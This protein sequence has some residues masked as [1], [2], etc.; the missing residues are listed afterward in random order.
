MESKLKIIKWKSDYY[1][2]VIHPRYVF[3]KTCT[4]TLIE[5][6]EIGRDLFYDIISKHNC[7]IEF[8]HELNNE[9]KVVT[10]ERIY[11]KNKKHAENILDALQSFELIKLLRE[12]NT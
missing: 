7:Q 5:Y 6:L 10:T 12:V 11:F 8:Y 9:K 1:I 4:S 3:K 2:D